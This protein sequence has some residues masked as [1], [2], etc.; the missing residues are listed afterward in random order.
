[1]N[2]RIGTSGYSFQ[3][4]KGMFYPSKIS[5]SA[6]LEYYAA[7]FD[8]VEINVTYYRVPPPDVFRGMVART[9]PG[10][11]FTVKL[12]KAMTHDRNPKESDFK[13]MRD[14][15]E[16]LAEKG[17]LLGLLAQFP[18]SFRDTPD[19][20]DYLTWLRGQLAGHNL[21]VEFRHDSWVKSDGIAFLE[22]NNTG[23]CMVDEPQLD[24][25]MPLV[26][27][28][29]GD[30]AYVRFHGRNA[31]DWWHP[32]PGGDRYAYDYSDAEL[33]EWLPRVKQSEIKATSMLIYF[34]NCHMGAA[35]LNATRFREMLELPPPQPQARDGELPF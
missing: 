16:P 11:G 21:H 4:W 35:A 19:N 32:R 10:F 22:R 33:A 3:D 26:V 27:A 5:S 14:S 23:Y 6:M 25:L 13:A 29:A 7:K 31:D 8:T 17:K 30:V 1:M 15:L 9:P 20:R 24:G 2:I 34:N 28:T 12:H 18:S